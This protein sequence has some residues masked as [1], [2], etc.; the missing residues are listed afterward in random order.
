MKKQ[1]VNAGAQ[2]GNSNASIWGGKTDTLGVVLP[3]E[4]AEYWREKA[5]QDRRSV[6]QTLAIALD[7]E[8]QK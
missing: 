5:K 8:K 1:I 7:P 3:A 4:W 6:S 2:P